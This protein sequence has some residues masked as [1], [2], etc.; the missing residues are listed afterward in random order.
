MKKIVVYL[1]VILFVFICVTTAG[2]GC[3]DFGGGWGSGEVSNKIFIQQ[4]N[5]FIK[6]IHDL[7]I[8]IERQGG[9]EQ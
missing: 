4:T 1:I 3:T 5:K 9:S 6:E 7:R 2:C 8:A